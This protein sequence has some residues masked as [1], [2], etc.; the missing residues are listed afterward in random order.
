[1][2]FYH[3]HILPHLIGFACGQPQ[4][5][6]KR[7]QIVPLATGRV[8]EVGFGA[9]PNLSFYDPATV[10]HLYAL[11]PSEGMRRKA[12]DAIAACPVNVELIDL[13]G[14]EIP[15]EDASIDTVVMTY[16]L[17]TIPDA[18]AALAQISRV[19]KP[20]GKLLFSEHGG[21]PDA[22]VAKWQ[23]RIE[24]V[25][26]PIAG[27]CH[28][29]RHPDTMMQAAGFG[30]ERLEAMYLPKSPKFASFNYAGIAVKT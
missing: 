24:P 18:E 26:K 19:L 12:A 27:G 25:W 6:K 16:T 3:E 4:I 30:I 15:L 10:S 8:L 11:E 29:T 13:P 2:S 21:A 9:G 1:M 28:L 20:G 5:M 14:E 17:C 23:R 22:D 7:S